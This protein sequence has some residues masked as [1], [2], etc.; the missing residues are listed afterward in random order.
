[1]CSIVGILASQQNLEVVLM[2]VGYALRRLHCIF[3][4]SRCWKL[5]ERQNDKP[6][7]QSYLLSTSLE[8]LKR[9]APTAGLY[10]HCLSSQATSSAATYALACTA[11]WDSH[12]R[13]VG[14]SR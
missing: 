6:Q 2:S 12:R 4:T 10:S 1:M 9:Q 3:D 5:S 14:S 13:V 11:G 8:E 7:A